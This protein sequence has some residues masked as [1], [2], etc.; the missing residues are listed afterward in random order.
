MTFGEENSLLTRGSFHSI[1]RLEPKPSSGTQVLREPIQLVAIENASHCLALSKREKSIE[2]VN[3][4]LG[5][6]IKPEELDMTAFSLDTI[7]V[8]RT[9]KANDGVTSLPNGELVVGRVPKAPNEQMGEK[10]VIG[11]GHRLIENQDKNPLVRF[12]TPVVDRVDRSVSTSHL[13]ITTEPDPNIP[14]GTMVFV[15][16]LG[17]TNGTWVRHDKFDPKNG[18]KIGQE[19]TRLAVGEKRRLMKDNVVYLGNDSGSAKTS[20]AYKGFETAQGEKQGMA[21]FEVTSNP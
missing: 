14:G 3:K 13:K 2:A 17:S 7:Y 8:Q 12:G 20:L 16:D 11:V 1:Q 9:G 21:K 6:P 19:D 4:T 5:Q 10:G 18:Q 15:E